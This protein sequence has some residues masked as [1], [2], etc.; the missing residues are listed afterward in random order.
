MALLRFTGF[1]TLVLSDATSSGGTV[2][3][4]TT[5]K[6]TGA[7]ALRCNPTTTAVGWVRIGGLNSLGSNASANVA[8]M[9]ST[10]YFYIAT[11]PASNDEGF[12]DVNDTVA[13]VKLHLRLNSSRQIVVYDNTI[14]IVATGSTALSTSTWYRIEVMTTTSASASNYEVKIDGVSE[15]SGTCTQGNTN[16][17]FIRLGK[18]TNYNSNTVDFYYDDLAL[19]DSAYLGAGEIK[20]MAPD[21]DGSTQQWTSGTAPSDYTQIDEQTPSDTDYVQSN[22]SASQLALFNLESSSSAGISGTINAFMAIARIKENATGTSSNIVRVKSSS[23]T[24]DTSALNYTTTY[25]YTH[26]L[27]TVDPNTSAAW[28]TG[29]L[30]A[31]E[32]GTLENNAVAMVCSYVSGFAYYT[33]SV[34]SAIKTING[35]AKAS[36]KTVNGLAIASVKT[37]DGLS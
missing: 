22:G 4:N 24:N 10:F 6:R 19:S 18:Q 11:A 7:A 14:T 32:I 27:T 9:Y 3:V 36:I 37:W 16:N 33:P 5:T 29:G 34:G 35:L 1:E 30:D 20:R 28:T 31:V 2:S 25:A 23:A 12:C 21:S 8:T 15:L 13:N 26:K 17:G